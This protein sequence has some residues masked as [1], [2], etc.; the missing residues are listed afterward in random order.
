[1][2]YDFFNKWAVVFIDLLIEDFDLDEDS[3]I[4]IV[5]N[6]G[7]E[8]GGF[9]SLQEKKPL[10]PGSRGGYGIMQ[11][12]GPRRKDYE[13]YCKRNK[14]KPSDMMSN[15]KFLF[16][17]LKGPEGSVLPVLVQ[18]KTLNEKV[19]IFMRKFLRPGIPHLDNRIVWAN[20]AKEA[21]D[22]R[23]ATKEND[24]MN[25]VLSLVTSLLGKNAKAIG[26]G[27]GALL[28]QA[29]DPTVL[30]PVV[31]DPQFQVV[32]VNV[33]GALIGAWFAPKNK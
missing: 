7:H 21:W 23:P 4:A 15:Y 26:A 27:I 5:G 2:T 30:G 3:A 6:A 11:W 25:I 10:V 24:L 9:Q 13:K 14:L 20:R 18:G 33:V 1:M 22:K 31:T 28:A 32:I 8:S 16:V 29:V 19:E 12:T 17:E